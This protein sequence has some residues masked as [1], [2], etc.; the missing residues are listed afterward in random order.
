VLF[1]VPHVISGGNSRSA[2]AGA[3]V[4]PEAGPAL[5]EWAIPAERMEKKTIRTT[6]LTVCFFVANKLFTDLH[7]L[8]VF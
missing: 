7:L 5:S 3:P 8:Y 1:I 4:K 6:I 2:G